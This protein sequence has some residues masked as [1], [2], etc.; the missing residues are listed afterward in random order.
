MDFSE[1][2]EYDPEVMVTAKIAISLPTDIWIVKNREK[3]HH[4]TV[5][6]NGLDTADAVIQKIKSNPK[7]KSSNGNW[8][9]TNFN[10]LDGKR[11]CFIPGKSAIAE[12]NLVGNT[13]HLVHKVL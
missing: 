11:K 1:C 8:R 10:I 7:L 13:F 9:N 12:Y 3:N 2:K 5:I 4:I 6:V